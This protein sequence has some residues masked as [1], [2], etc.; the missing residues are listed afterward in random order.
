MRSG[1]ISIIAF[2]SPGFIILTFVYLNSGKY[3]GLFEGRHPMS[4]D[5]HSFFPCTLEFIQN[6]NL[7]LG[8]E[9]KVRKTLNCW[10]YGK[11]KG[12][13]FSPWVEWRSHKW[14]KIKIPYKSAHEWLAMSDKWGILPILSSY[15]SF[16]NIPDSKIET[17]KEQKI[18]P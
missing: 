7:C 5:K 13:D 3:Q 18:Y 9:T 12:L 14:G 10:S 11:K 6:W 16:N 2:N 8:I 4:I 15:P 17:W 1:T